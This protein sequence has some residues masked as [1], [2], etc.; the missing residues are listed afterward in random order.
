M[1]DKTTTP[2]AVDPTLGWY[3]TSAI[4]FGVYALIGGI[5]SLIA[6]AANVRPGRPSSRLIYAT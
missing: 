3:R 1:A 5:I 2:G 6:W 4:F